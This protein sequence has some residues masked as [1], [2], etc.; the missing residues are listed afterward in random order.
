MHAHA[1][2]A[3]SPCAAA[4]RR[5]RRFALGAL[6]AGAVALFW[7]ILRS[8]TKP[9][10][11]TYPCQQAAFSTASLA[12]GLPL[13][14]LLLAARRRIAAHLHTGVATVLAGVAML[15]VLTTAGQFAPA[16]PYSGPQLDPPDGYRAA[17]YHV[18]LCPPDP[19]GERFIGLD[20][21]LLAMGRGGLKF[22]NS[23]A[24][25]PLAGPDGV[26]GRDDVILI[27]INYQWPERGGT[28]TDVLRGLIRRIVDHPDGFV[29]EVVVVENAQFN[30]TSGFNRTLNNAQNRALSPLAVVTG[31]QQQGWRISAFDWTN[32]RYSSVSEYSAGSLT[33]G[34]VVGPY[35]AQLQGRVSYPKFRSAQGTYISLRYGIWDP[36]SQTY[37]RDHLKFVN[38]P[39]LKSHHSTYGATACVKHYMGVVTRE[40]S[41]NSHSAIGRGILGALQAQ[42]RPADLTIL[43]CIW[44]NANPLTGP[45]T[46]YTGATRRDEL[47]GGRDPV[48]IDRWAVKNILI[49]GFLSNGFTPPW[50]PPSADPDDPNSAFR[51]YLDR[52]MSYLLNAGYNV[53]NDPAQIDVTTWSGHGDLDCDGRVT[54]DDINPF[55][56][57]LNGESGY[58]AQFPYCIWQNADCNRDG[59]VN[60]DDIN[61]FVALLTNPQ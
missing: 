31:F 11:I 9:S 58:A 24:V 43:D 57:A 13:I 40:L 33:D 56:L 21:L 39:V 23:P 3:E 46:P 37:D 1:A 49:A 15:V 30:S 42:I 45:Q 38:V 34:Y 8:G 52:S 55:V 12:F 44:I 51:Q 28:N 14:G 41:T 4:R 5:Q 61:A 32:I 10:R 47:V 7:L 54:F 25:T 50:P 53:T 48:A 36:N 35:D 29:G 27:K 19:V 26:L 17:L 16:E 6:I 60:F 59:Q 22:Y 20:R 18:P 2:H